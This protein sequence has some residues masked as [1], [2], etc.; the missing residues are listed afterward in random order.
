MYI[1]AITTCKKTENVPVAEELRLGHCKMIFH[2]M[3]DDVCQCTMI[4]HVMYNDLYS[5]QQ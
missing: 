2:I 5:V 1:Y 3:Y 4:F